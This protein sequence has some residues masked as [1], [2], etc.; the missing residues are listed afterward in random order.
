MRRT[1]VLRLVGGAALVGVAV[2]WGGRRARSSSS[3]DKPV[4]HGK[5]P[6]MHVESESRL[7]VVNT[8][9]YEDL[10][11]LSER[12]TAAVQSSRKYAGT[13]RFGRGAAPSLIPESLRSILGLGAGVEVSE[14]VRAI[15]ALGS[16]LSAEEFESLYNYV[17]V[18][19][20]VDSREQRNE[21]WL[22]NEIMDKL[23]GQEAVPAGLADVMA[24]VFQDRQQGT[25][26]RDYAIQH[27][28][29]IYARVSAEEQEGLRATM[30]RGAGETDSSIAGTSLLALLKISR[31]LASTPTADGA[32]DDQAK[33]RVRL[34]QAA[35]RLASDEQC[36][37]LARITAVQIC[38]R[39][40]VEPALSV[41]GRLAQG[42][43]SIPLRIASIAA[44]GDIGGEQAEALLQ[45]LAQDPEVRLVPA[46]R[47]ALRRLRK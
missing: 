28:P 16:N 3:S 17:L 37:E 46:T 29:P 26:M 19:S 31:E 1:R 39:L 25:V 6:F 47:S 32:L 34:E 10:P 21:Y 11:V 4:Q 5:P 36:G 30:W 38:G 8:S 27:I 18:P 43:P 13:Q 42:A 44:L 22:R 2:W 14:R 12:L 20:H 24:K 35:L 23:A 7:R 41:V 9:S 15:R 33:E 40:G 45:Q